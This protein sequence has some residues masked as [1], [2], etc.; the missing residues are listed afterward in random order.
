MHIYLQ[1]WE[2][3]NLI[4]SLVMT[5]LPS[6]WFHSPLQR[7]VCR[8]LMNDR[9]SLQYVVSVLMFSNDSTAARQ[10]YVC[11]VRLLIIKFNTASFLPTFSS[12]YMSKKNNFLG[13]WFCVISLKNKSLQYS[14][15]RYFTGVIYII[16]HTSQSCT[17]V[18]F[19]WCVSCI[20]WMLFGEVV[21]AH[22]DW[23]SAEFISETA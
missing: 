6:I 7:C 2:G 22:L 15:C 19:M 3:N 13:C 20:K 10:Q 16:G 23:M 5:S 1:L 4:A 9:N 8:T 17:D 12:G 21:S 14:I 18:I 11:V